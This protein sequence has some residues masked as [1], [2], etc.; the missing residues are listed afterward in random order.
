MKMKSQHVK[1]YGILEPWAQHGSLVAKV[2]EFCESPSTKTVKQV[3][4]RV[5]KSTM[6]NGRFVR[7]GVL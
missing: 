6:E 2:N 7:K 3:L 1:I 5:W 4:M